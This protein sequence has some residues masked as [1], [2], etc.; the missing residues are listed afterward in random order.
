[1]S[2]LDHNE[3]QIAAAASAAASAAVSSVATAEPLSARSLSA[4]HYHFSG[5]A[6]DYYHYNPRLPP[7]GFVPDTLSF[8]CPPDSLQQYV[9]RPLDQSQSGQISCA[10]A[11]SM[12]TPSSNINMALQPTITLAYNN[13]ADRRNSY[14]VHPFQMDQLTTSIH[15]LEAATEP[16]VKLEY[17][18]DNQLLS[19]FSQNVENGI[20]PESSM[21][22]SP[23]S[24]SMDGTC[25]PFDRNMKPVSSIMRQNREYSWSIHDSSSISHFEMSDE[26]QGYY[27]RHGSVGSLYPLT[28]HELLEPIHAPT[29]RQMEGTPMVATDS[30]TSILSVASMT[31][32]H[33]NSSSSSSSSSPPP[34]PT[35]ARVRMRRA[36]LNPDGSSRVFTCSVEECARVFK[37]SEHLKRHV[38]SVHTLEKRTFPIS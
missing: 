18:Y 35:P 8:T 10:S 34:P 28:Q 7:Q 20:K 25:S 14:G 33:S 31:S 3:Q 27:P 30:S 15:D 1:M 24:L 17:Q 2:I 21:S 13:T 32:N 36:S 23:Q 19:D 16:R 22:Y 12:T 9:S 29:S 6:N 5:F 4:P 26:Y 37:R 38:R 11:L